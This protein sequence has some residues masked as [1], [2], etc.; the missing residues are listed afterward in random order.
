MLNK[1]FWLSK[2]VTFTEKDES[3]IEEL[4]LF[5]IPEQLINKQN[6][7]KMINNLNALFCLLILFIEY[8]HQT[9][10]YYLLLLFKSG[11]F[12]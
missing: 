7:N 4:E 9:E 2:F 10:T 11:Y 6:D 5:S 3:L 12:E 1:L 8:E